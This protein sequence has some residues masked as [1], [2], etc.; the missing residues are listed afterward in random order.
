[1]CKVVV[2]CG[3][4]RR[5]S[6]VIFVVVMGGGRVSV[7]GSRVITQRSRLVRLGSRRRGRIRGVREG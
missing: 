6:F 3:G 2:R 4:V 7:N 1:M 5:V